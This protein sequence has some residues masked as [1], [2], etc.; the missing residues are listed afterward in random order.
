ML[1]GYGLVVNVLPWDFG[2]LLGT[3]VAAFAVAGRT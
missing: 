3:Y 2:R 1:A